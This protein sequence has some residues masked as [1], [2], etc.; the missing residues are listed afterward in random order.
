MRSELFS[1]LKPP[2]DA[3]S[4]LFLNESSSVLTPKSKVNIYISEKWFRID[5]LERNTSS[6]YNND[7]LFTFHQ[8][9]I[10]DRCKENLKKF[11]SSYDKLSPFLYIG[12]NRA[13]VDAKHLPGSGLCSA[14]I[15]YLN[16]Y[17]NEEPDMDISVANMDF[18]QNDN[19]SIS[20]VN[21]LNYLEPSVQHQYCSGQG[22]YSI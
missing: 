16:C 2:V 4:L 11:S 12:L 15:S 18:K 14:N 21:S 10:T 13:I 6:Y 22:F 17:T 19:E 8:Q 5:N 20:W 1:D 7:F 9:N 3:S